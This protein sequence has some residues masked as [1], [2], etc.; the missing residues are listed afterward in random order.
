VLAIPPALT[1]DNAA[2]G[3]GD[4]LPDFDETDDDAGVAADAGAEAAAEAESG[5][6]TP[7]DAEHRAVT[8]PSATEGDA[9]EPDVE[10]DMNEGTVS[11]GRACVVS[12]DASYTRGRRGPLEPRKR[13]G[14]SRRRMG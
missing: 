11:W 12:A 7:T 14:R 8:P 9:G 4:E 3:E 5:Q 1:M 10:M 2:V 6:E 13:A